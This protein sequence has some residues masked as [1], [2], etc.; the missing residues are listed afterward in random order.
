MFYFTFSRHSFSIISQHNFLCSSL[1]SAFLP[2]ANFL[3]LREC[4]VFLLFPF[5]LYIIFPFL[6]GCRVYI[7]HNSSFSHFRPLLPPLPHILLS[8]LPPMFLVSF[9]FFLCFI[10]S[11]AI[12]YFLSALSHSCRLDWSQSQHAVVSKQAPF[13]C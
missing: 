6:F 12:C 9:G 11:M 4:L 2:S 8:F 7:C 1:L 3:F 5:L 13:C 10:S